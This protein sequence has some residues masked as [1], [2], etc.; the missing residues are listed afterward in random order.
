MRHGGGSLLTPRSWL[1]PTISAVGSEIAGEGAEKAGLGKTGR[2]VASLG[3]SMLAD[4]LFDGLR[5]KV[6][7]NASVIY[8]KMDEKINPID[9]KTADLNKV[10]KNAL[11]EMG[12]SE[13]TPKS[14]TDQVTKIQNEAK[15]PQMNL[16]R[17]RSYIKGMNRYWYKDGMYELDKT[18]RG[19]F[20]NVKT[21]LE[22]TLEKGMKTHGLSNL[23]K[24]Y[25]YAKE[26]TTGM[27]ES[28]FALG[29]LKKHLANH[30]GIGRSLWRTIIHVAPEGA[31]PALLGMNV[32][33][34]TGG[35]V[36]AIVGLG[37]NTVKQAYKFL[38]T[39]TAM[40]EFTKLAPAAFAGNLPVVA[41]Q[42]GILDEMYEK[43]KKKK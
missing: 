10:S 20:T 21:S 16:G 42:M 13:A 22:D 23:H 14:F 30:K 28:E 11:T 2:F 12:F 36:G 43:E 4:P 8:N 32:A 33:G 15:L 6:N 40:K 7:K 38:A 26:I 18:D 37:L 9:L 39:P 41:R 35:T 17:V 31:A 3:F 19:I 29:I 34:T 24:E 1:R 5:D 25:K 27:K